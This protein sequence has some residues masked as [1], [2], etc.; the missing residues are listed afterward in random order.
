MKSDIINIRLMTNGSFLIHP[1]KNYNIYNYGKFISKNKSIEVIQKIRFQ[2]DEKAK[3]ILENGKTCDD[4]FTYELITL[5]NWLTLI[6]NALTHASLLYKEELTKIEE[7]LIS[8]KH[9][10]RK[11]K[12]N[13]KRYDIDYAEYSHKLLRL[14]EFEFKTELLEREY[15]IEL[16]KELSYIMS[17]LVE[18]VEK[19]HI[20]NEGLVFLKIIKKNEE[21]LSEIILSELFSDGVNFDI[22]EINSIVK[23]TQ[24]IHSQTYLDCMN[25]IKYNVLVKFRLEKRLI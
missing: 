10:I 20:F 17:C 25:S 19:A 21:I 5:S 1:L 9:Y 3:G 14:K 15:I 16:L 8:C 7:Q 12:S 13:Y 24:Y 4:L 2:L 18:D 6:E 11:Y 23:G 22:R